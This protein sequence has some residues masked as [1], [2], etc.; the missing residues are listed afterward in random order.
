MIVDNSYTWLCLG[1]GNNMIVIHCCDSWS[2]IVI[3][4]EL[5]V[6]VVVVGN[7]N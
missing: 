2:I 4:I 1:L 3:M 5:L 6:I 7:I